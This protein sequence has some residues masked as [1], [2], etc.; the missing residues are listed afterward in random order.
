M[1]IDEYLMPMEAGITVVDAM[2]EYTESTGRSIV[3]VSKLNFQV[4]FCEVS[5]TP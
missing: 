4:S 3:D 5:T 2:H 1:D